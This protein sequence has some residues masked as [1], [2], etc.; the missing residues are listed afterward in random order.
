MA[1]NKKSKSKKPK[2]KK[3][4]ASASA[5]P[6]VANVYQYTFGYAT[7]SPANCKA[8]AN[9]R[10]LRTQ[11]EAS[12][13]ELVDMLKRNPWD[14]HSIVTAKEDVPAEGSD[15]RANYPVPLAELME[16][17]KEDVSFICQIPV[18]PIF[19]LPYPQILLAF[20]TM[21]DGTSKSRY[22]S[23]LKITGRKQRNLQTSNYRG[24]G[25]K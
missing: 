23:E 5:P 3:A 19:L 17:S 20:P 7:L 11:D 8:G 4:P 18:F 9:I 1:P 22:C 14:P 16:M 10:Q 12:F 2:A 13:K 15:E 21:T 6:A 25:D 24:G